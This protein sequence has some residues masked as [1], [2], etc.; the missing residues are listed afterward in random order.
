MN[1]RDELEEI[2]AED[3]TDPETIQALRETYEHTCVENETVTLALRAGVAF[4]F[5]YSSSDDFNEI[6]PLRTKGESSNENQA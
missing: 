6:V 4:E 3:N 1:H 2:W 5:K